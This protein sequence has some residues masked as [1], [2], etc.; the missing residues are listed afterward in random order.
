VICQM[1]GIQYLEWQVRLVEPGISH[2]Y[3]PLAFA[4]ALRGNQG[5][6]GTALD[7]S[8]GN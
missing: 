8:N 3:P 2:H 4:V 7:F 1:Y 6:F 5:T